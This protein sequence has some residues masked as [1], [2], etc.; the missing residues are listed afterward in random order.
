MLLRNVWIKQVITY[1]AGYCCLAVSKKMKCEFCKDL[2]S[3]N[4]D[5]H[6]LPDNHNY[7]QGI[8]RDALLYPD[9]SVVNIV[10]YN[11][12]VITKLTKYSEFAKSV[13]QRKQSL[14]DY[15]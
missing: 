11:Y 3:N 15:T 5:I 14:G 8:S 4:E 9:D 7:I 1:L 6:S 2:L 12:I 13:N 10:M